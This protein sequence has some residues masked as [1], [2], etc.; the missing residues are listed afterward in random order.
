M[1]RLV[2]IVI[3]IGF[4]LIH[5]LSTRRR[6]TR[7]DLRLTAPLRSFRSPRSLGSPIIAALAVIMLLG[8]LPAILPQSSAHAASGYLA[9]EIGNTEISIDVE[10]TVQIV[11]WLVDVS[12]LAGYDCAITVSGPGTAVDTAAHGD[13]FADGHSVTAGGTAT[14]TYSS[15]MLSNPTYISGSGDLVV[16]TIRGDDDGVVAINIDEDIFCLGDKDADEIVITTPST[17]YITVGTGEGDSMECNESEEL[18]GEELLDGGS[19][20]YVD[21]DVDT[22]GDGS[23]LVACHRF[24]TAT[25]T[26]TTRVPTEGMVKYGKVIYAGTTPNSTQAEGE[27][28]TI[29]SRTFP[30]NLPADTNYKIIVVNNDDESAPIYW[31]N[32][33]PIDGDADMT[34]RVN[35]LDLIF[36]RNKLNLDPG[37]GENW[38]ADVT[39]DSRI[40]ILDL[41]YVRNKLNTQCPNE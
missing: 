7:D 9:D 13:W 2:G 28:L 37:A 35:I 5:I 10:D 20:I 16:F 22:S 17:L 19:T 15:A 26:W 4:G 11:L 40:N 29:H 32:P 41:I 18:G 8:V 38:K 6:A 33:W 36:I 31:P 1:E 14:A 23:K 25:V 34:C 3:S 24:S 39:Q 27:F 30:I 21:G 12:E